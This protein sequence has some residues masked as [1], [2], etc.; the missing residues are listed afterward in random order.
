MG[1]HF[2]DE[3]LFPMHFF[4]IYYILISIYYFSFMMVFVHLLNSRDV[5]GLV[6]AFYYY[7]YYLGWYDKTE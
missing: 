3:F 7:Y 6:Q 4:I 1:S 2:L 5:P